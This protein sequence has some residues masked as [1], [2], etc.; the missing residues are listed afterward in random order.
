MIDEK[1]V[2]NIK[3]KNYIIYERKVAIEFMGLI[4]KKN[5]S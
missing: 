2:V 3:G 4:K 1:Y 5:P